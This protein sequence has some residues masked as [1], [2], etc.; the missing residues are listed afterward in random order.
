[1]GS[2]LDALSL[3][4][5]LTIFASL[6]KNLN[7]LAKTT[8]PKSACKMQI[9]H[10]GHLSNS[11]TSF[12]PEPWGNCGITALQRVRGEKSISPCQDIWCHTRQPNELDEQK[13]SWGNKRQ[14]T[15]GM[16]HWGVRQKLMTL[17]EG[18]AEIS[19]MNCALIFSPSDSDHTKKKG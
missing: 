15:R 12:V 13:V 5:N 4:S 7:S 6:F 8:A 17:T 10:H 2:T 3:E 19:G 14:H 18:S 9:S 16:N 1:M 11:N